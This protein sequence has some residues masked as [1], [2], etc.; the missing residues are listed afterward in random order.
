MTKM[1]TVCID[2]EDNNEN[3][4]ALL[5][6]PGEKDAEMKILNGIIGKRAV[7]LFNELMG[8]TKDAG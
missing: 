6:F 4:A 5:V 7:A 2:Y 8:E 3:D 1:V